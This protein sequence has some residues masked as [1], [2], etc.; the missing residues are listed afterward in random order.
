MPLISEVRD[1]DP[2]AR[3]SR[4]SLSPGCSWERGPRAI[5]STV[6]WPSPPW[7]HGRLRSPQRGGQGSAGGCP[8]L[9]CILAHRSAGQRREGAGAGGG[10]GCPPPCPSPLCTTAQAQ[11]NGRRDAAGGAVPS[12]KVAAWQGGPSGADAASPWKRR[13]SDVSPRGGGGPPL[14]V[15]GWR[16]GPREAPRTC[17]PPG[18]GFGVEGP[19]RVPPSGPPSRNQ[20]VH[21]AVRDSRRICGYPQM[22]AA[23]G[24]LHRGLPLHGG[25]APPRVYLRKFLRWRRASTSLTQMCAAIPGVTEDAHRRRAPSVPLLRQQALDHVPVDVARAEIA[26]L[27]PVRQPGVVEAEPM[28]ETRTFLVRG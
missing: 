14:Y 4:N 15:A 6:A 12:G 2:A 22:R 16:G 18:S 21:A 17:S 13:H 27:E 1:C 11:G 28:Q 8:P 5:G 26:A 25:A 23:S 9:L 7:A 24:R 10:R 20:P 19:R 3:R